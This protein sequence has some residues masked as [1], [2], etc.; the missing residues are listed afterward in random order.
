MQTHEEPPNVHSTRI[1]I[2]QMHTRHARCCCDGSGGGGDNCALEKSITIG[3]S[4]CESKG[5]DG[6]GNANAV[7]RAF[8]P[9]STLDDDNDGP[10]RQQS[11]GHS[12]LVVA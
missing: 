8:L 10:N 1:R 6:S 12:L 3:N 7:P 5:R 4:V 9:P 11:N 2:N